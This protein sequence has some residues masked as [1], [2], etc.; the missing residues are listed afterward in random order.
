VLAGVAIEVSVED[1]EK[2]E[3]EEEEE[4]E[5]EGLKSA[6]PKGDCVGRVKF[7][8]GT[9]G[10]GAGIKAGRGAGAGAGGGR[11]VS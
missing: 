11:K 8:A 4:E 9:V 2:V 3:E 7:M 6:P 10:M 1:E 5:E